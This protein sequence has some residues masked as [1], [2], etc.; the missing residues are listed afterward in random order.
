MAPSNDAFWAA[1]ATADEAAA[2]AS[3]RSPDEQRVVAAFAKLVRGGTAAAFDELVAIGGEAGDGRARAWAIQSLLDVLRLEGR[4]D[5]LAT[6]RAE[7]P[8]L[9]LGAD[10]IPDVLTRLRPLTIEVAEAPSVLPFATGLQGWAAVQVQLVGD[11]AKMEATAVVDTGAGMCVVDGEHAERLGV[12]VV[13]GNV[14]LLG[15]SGGRTAGRVGVL[16]ELRIGGVTAREVPVAIVDGAPL[17]DLAGVS[18][19]V[20]WEV[21]QYVALEFI[22]SARQLVVRRSAGALA[23]AAPVPDLLLLHEPVVRLRSGERSLLLL[24]DS[25]AA[26]TEF[27]LSC[28]ARMG[29]PTQQGGTAVT[30]LGGGGAGEVRTITSCPIQCGNVRLDLGG[31]LAVER[32]ATREKLLRIDGTLGVDVA[33]AVRLVVDGPARTVAFRTD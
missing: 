31:A 7:H 2:G 11:A 33:F 12:R 15:I 13:E 8:R 28:A 9:G 3:V 23:M 27:R 17:R 5:R 16:R 25:G 21:L 14:P 1:M 10:A 30:G 19:L 24:L 26:S 18:C 6:L 32:L 4:W 22:G 29:W 20:G